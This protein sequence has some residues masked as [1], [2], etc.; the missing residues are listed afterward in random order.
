MENRAEAP[1]EEGLTMADGFSTEVVIKRKIQDG[2]HVYTCD[3]LPGL[4]VVSK[5]DRIAYHDVLRSIKAL[6]K[7]DFGIDCVVGHKVGYAEF[8]EQ[9]QLAQRARSAVE[10]RT[11]ELMSGGVEMIPF[12]V[13][14]VHDR[15]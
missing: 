3:Q 7:L 10:E 5:D 1:N 2:W 8:I 9:F 11:A 13:Q 14:S 15:C 6:I 4:F 12:T